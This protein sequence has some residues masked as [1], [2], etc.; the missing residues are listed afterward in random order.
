MIR[1]IGLT[2]LVVTSFLAAMAPSAHAAKKVSPSSWAEDFCTALDDWQTTIQD[3]SNA[4]TTELASVTDLTEGRD[5]LAAFLGDMVDATDEATDAIK[6]A[7]A[8][9]TPN[10][11]KISKVFVNG[12]K[13]ISKEFAKAEAKAEEL[14]TTS[15][16]KFKTQGQDLGQSLSEY[17]DTLGKSFSSVGKLDKGKKLEKAV[18]AA[19][20]CAFLDA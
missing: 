10:G 20:E 1:R 7:G 6:D 8:P 2:A 4:M 18:K 13:E 11:A 17:G 19:P 9:S 15:P 12:F 5:K 3:K 16:T 14:S